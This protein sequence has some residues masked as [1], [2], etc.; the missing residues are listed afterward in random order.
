M[1]L[2][3]TAIEDIQRE[4]KGFGDGV[5]ELK[6][7]ME[8]DL[9][10]VRKL[11]E[12][13]K[14]AGTT[15]HPETKQAIEA[16]TTS[17]TEKHAAVEALLSE[18]KE[19][20]DRLETAFK[21]LPTSVEDPKA[22]AAEAKAV[23]EFYKT[24]AANSGQLNINTDFDLS[25]L[26]VEGYK[27]WN[28]QFKTYMR[29]RDDRA[30][31]AKALS[32]GSNPDGGY[33]VPTA[34]SSR[35]IGRVYEDSPIRQ[36]ANVE[37][38]GTSEMEIAIDQDEAGAGWVGEET[39]RPET[40]TPQTGV[41]RIVVHE[42]YA[43]P[44]ATQKLLEDASIDIE[45]WLANKVAEKFAR[46]EAT[47]FVVGDGVNKPRGFLTYPATGSS[48]MVVPQVVS[49]DASLLLPDALIRLPFALKSA[50]LGNAR[51]VMNRQTIASIMLFKDANEQYIWRPG[52]QD[53]VPSVIGGYPVTMADDMPVVA[54]GSLPIAFGDFRRA[55]TIVDRLGITTLRDPLTAKPFVLFYTRK[56]VGGDMVDFDA[57]VLMKVAAA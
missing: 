29:S 52:L 42:I 49:G 35:I 56:R 33:F 1:P 44:K 34:V 57:L 47:A 45:A 14:A 48:R 7:S 21:R 23:V 37:T 50:Y 9:E 31:E 18:R 40:S 20:A 17:V 54:A 43:M 8:K 11:A 32:V 25:K 26:D 51:W 6:T 36:I 22:A 16:L 39:P 10:A 27:S 3:N 12:E 2:D 46:M 53:G 24:K 38:I 19:Q 15:Q 30:V 5:K 41:Q 55:Y 28:Q 4:I 13:A